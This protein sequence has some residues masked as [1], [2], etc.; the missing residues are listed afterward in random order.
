MAPPT[1]LVIGCGVAGPVIAILLKRKGYHPIVFEKVREL[2]NAGASLML[3]SN[4]LN[5]F[6][7]IGVAD[8][9]KAESLPL[10]TLWD[11]KA[12]GEILGQSNLPSTWAESYRQPAAGIKRTTL[13]LLLKEKAGEEG[14]EVREGWALVDIQ[15]HEDSVTA[16]FGNGQSVTGSFLVGCD[17]IKSASR[18]ILQKQRGVEEGLPSYTGLTQTA[19]ISETP[20]ALQNTAAMRNWYGDGVH[21]I[22]YPVGPK[23]MSWALTQRE[24]QEREETWRPF[25]ADELDTQRDALCKLLDGWDASIAQGVRSAERIIK[26][27]LFDREELRPDQWFSR[28]CVLIGDAAH[29]TSPHLGQGANQAME[30]CYHLSTMLPNLAPNSQHEDGIDKSLNILRSSSLSE[31][32]FRPFAEKRQPRTSMLVKG[33]RAQGEV[34]VA[35]GREKGRERDEMIAKSYEG[36]AAAV[37]AKFENLL[38]QP[39]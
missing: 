21:V 22:A 6:D 26:Y 14:I 12:S 7:L 8:A 5:V 24:T 38:K 10:T 37:V 18:A 34:R 9:I 28:R 33:A 23:T 31:S 32:V 30:D 13:N 11:A 25:T 1:V 35:V 27:G 20:V 19:F 29:P 15:E 2:G 39:F 17:G 36:N 3:M 16:T 4:G